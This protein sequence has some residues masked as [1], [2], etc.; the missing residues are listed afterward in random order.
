MSRRRLTTWPDASRTRCAGDRASPRLPD[1]A[2]TTRNYNEL[3]SAFFS[4][5]QSPEERAP[6]RGRHRCTASRRPKFRAMRLRGATMSHTAWIERSGSAMGCGYGGPCSSRSMS[7]CVHR[8]RPA[9]RMITHQNEAGNSASMA[10]RYFPYDQLAWPAVATLTGLP[11][12]VAPIG[13]SVRG[14]GGDSSR[15]IVCHGGVGGGGHRTGRLRWSCDT[16]TMA[17]SGSDDRGEIGAVRASGE[18]R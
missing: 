7:S 8:C 12:T 5:D 9:F 6:N 2:R 1:L 16:S 17:W 18:V 15:H 10:Q 3:L 13:A 11:A 14:R 4:A